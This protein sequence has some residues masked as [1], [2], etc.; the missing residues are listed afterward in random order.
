MFLP[1]DMNTISLDLE[2]CITDINITSVVKMWFRE[3]PDSLLTSNLHQGCVHAGSK[4]FV[5]PQFSNLS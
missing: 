2:E 4:H 1:A 5:L 3:L